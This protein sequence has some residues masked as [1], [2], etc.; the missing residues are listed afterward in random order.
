MLGMLY[1]DYDDNFVGVGVFG[2]RCGVEVPTGFICFRPWL[3]CWRV[4]S[5]APFYSGSVAS[6]NFA[7]SLSSL[8]RSLLFGCVA[9][10]CVIGVDGDGVD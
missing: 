6:V 4:R 3:L 2:I 1:D 5:S 7:L 9:S 10:R 8:T